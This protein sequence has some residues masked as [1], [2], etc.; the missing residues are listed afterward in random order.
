MPFI[1][2]LELNSFRSYDSATIDGLNQGFIALSGANGAGKTNVL[3][4]ISLV[5]HPRGLRSCKIQDAQRLGNADPLAIALR[6]TDPY[7]V[8]HFGVG[9]DNQHTGK[10]LRANGVSVRGHTAFA[11]SLRCVWLTP[12]MDGLFLQGSSDRRRFF[13]RLVASF[14]PAHQGRLTRY[15]KALSQRSKLLKDDGTPDPSWLSALETQLT[16][17]ATAIAA[18]RVDHLHRLRDQWES[19]IPSNLPFPRADISLI[20]FVEDKLEAGLS[21]VDIEDMLAHQFMTSR[22][23]DAITGGAQDGAH[24]TDMHVIYADKHMPAEQCSTG[25]Q[26]ALLVGLVLA[27]AAIL[28]K[29]HNQAPILLFDEVPAH[30][31]KARRQALFDVLSQLETQVW[32]SATDPD[33]YTHL[34]G[35]TTHLSITPGCIEKR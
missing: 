21:A 7:G 9:L 14:D 4:A 26:K 10:L 34:P 23:R 32:M 33:I 16:E 15:D 25:E 30:L 31:D 11:D 24:K 20:G 18:A 19:V 6:I 27:N 5:S 22:P 35:Q 17:T 8:Q 29:L 13:D 28:H 2:G 3:E 12:Q 1:S